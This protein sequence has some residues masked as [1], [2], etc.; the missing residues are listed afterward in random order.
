MIENFISIYRRLLKD[1]NYT[2]HRYLYDRFHIKDRLTGLI[3]PRGTGKTTLLLQFIKE[4][5]ENKDECIYVSLDNIYFS[6]ELLFDFVRVCYEEY[7]IRYFFLD[8]VHK[9]PTWSRELKNI[10]DSYPEVKVV[11]S[12]SSGMDLV[13]GTYDLS[14][15]RTLFH[16]NGMSFREYL[17]FNGIFY[18]DPFPLEEILKYRGILEDGIASVNKLKGHFKDYL[19]YGFYP[20]FMEGKE[21]YHRKLLRIVDKIIYEDIPH[22]YRLNTENLIAFRKILSFL[23]TIP[24]GEL[25]KNSISKNIGIDVKT[26]KYYLNILK[27]TGLVEL[28]ETG[29]KGGAMLRSREKIFLKNPNLY[30]AMGNAL[31]KAVEIGTVRE[32]FFVRMLKNAGINVFFS[33]VGD[34]ETSGYFFEIGG[35]SKNK[36]QFKGKN[37]NSFLVKDDILYGTKDEIPLYLF[38]F[39]Y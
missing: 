2:T 24:P 27:E 26:V 16:L 3:G 9:Y 31:G 22:F 7:G 21:S 14:R 36:R 4:K 23:S 11:F 28:V 30:Y 35:R 38:G 20:F 8:E 19:R 17:L 1:T 37:I 29:K 10:Y 32:I 33:K 5:M 12:G 34:F 13:M 25:S 6:R 39:L 15:R 18:T